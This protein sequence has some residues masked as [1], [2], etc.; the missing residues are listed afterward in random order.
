[1]KIDKR[2]LLNYSILIP[3]LIL[4]ILG[5]IVI[6]STTSAT[7]IQ[8]GANPFRS[9][10][11]QGVFWAVS[12]VAIIF[13]YK[14]KLNF[15]KN[16]KVLT[17]AVLVEVFLLLIAR[18]FTQEVNGAHGWIVIGP[19]SFQPAEYLKVIIVWYLAFTFDR[20]QKKIEIYDYQALTKG[21]WLPRSLSDLK[22]WRF[23]SLFM[24]GLV[25][26]QPDLGNGSIIVLTVIIMYCISGIGYRWFSALLGL[27]VVG[28]TLFIGTIAVVGVETMA[29][30]P[31]FGYVAKRF[32]AFFDPFKDLTDS[33]HQ[34][35]NS[36][37]AMSNGGWFGRGLGN[38]IEK[39]GYLPEATTD[40]V[41]SIVIEELGVI[42]A[43]FI[44]ALVFF[45]ILRIMHVG[46]KAKDPF[47]S[48]IALGIGAM[49]LMQVF[50]NIGGISGL[51]PSTGVTFPFLSQGGNSLLV[52]SVAIGFVLNIDANEKKELIMKEAEEQ[53]KPQ[54]KMKK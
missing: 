43:G 49:L 15:L 10:I 19:I 50:V 1:M 24:I 36:Y 51:I 18:F 40:F 2:H 29:K 27:I 33:G 23:Y 11:N 45:L 25:I 47:N 31:V 54:E 6:Y 32:N 34:L 26:A 41:F 3:Y 9:V 28:S 48:M 17:M 5:L 13:I 7:L 22:D 52:L 44:L 39:L 53:Y 16:S 12:L 42:G 4:S 35:A 14:L 21:R 8:L 30:V 38:S 20:R 46:I 37:Y